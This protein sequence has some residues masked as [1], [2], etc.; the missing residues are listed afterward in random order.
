VVSIP[1]SKS[2]REME[3]VIAESRLMHP[4]G[5]SCSRQGAHDHTFSVV[6][7]GRQAAAPATSNPDD[8]VQMADPW[9]GLRVPPGTPLIGMEAS[10]WL[11][12]RKKRPAS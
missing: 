10:P 6:G 2:A 1:V 3:E 5:R 12:S 7:C 4:G 9:S 11:L 8:R